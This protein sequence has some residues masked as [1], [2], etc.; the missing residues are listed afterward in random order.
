VGVFSGHNVDDTFRVSFLPRVQIL[1]LLIQHLFD[2]CERLG[3]LLEVSQTI[4][5]FVLYFIEK[6]FSTAQ[7]FCHAKLIQYLAFYQVHQKE[8]EKFRVY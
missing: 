2:L 6:F 7:I 3:V 8:K 4:F 5:L 1:I